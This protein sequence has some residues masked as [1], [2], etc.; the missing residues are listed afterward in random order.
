MTRDTS[1]YAFDYLSAQLRMQTGRNFAKIARKT[2]AGPQNI[3]HFMTHSPWSAQAVID[4]VQQEI[5]KTPALLQGSVLIL[6]ESA[7]EKTSELSV[8]AARQY[9]GRQGKVDMSQMGVFLGYA[10]LEVNLWSWVDAE[11]YLPKHWFFPDKQALSEK[12]GVPKERVFATKW[13]LGLSMILRAHATGLPFEMVACDAHYGQC[14]QFRRALSEAGILYF[15][16]VPATEAVYL[17]C[18]TFA[19]PEWSGKGRVP[20]IARV[21]DQTPA[22]SVKEVALLADT[23]WQ[24]LRVR[25]T[26]RGFLEEPFAFRQVFTLRDGYPVQEWLVM[27]NESEHK[28]SYAFSSAA[29]DTPVERLAQS[30]CVRYFVERCNQDAKSELGYDEFQGQ[31]WRCWEHHVGLTMLSCWFVA[32]TKL[33][34]SMVYPRDPLLAWEWE[35]DVLPALSTSNV[36][37]LLRATMPLPQLS[38]EEAGHLVVTHLVNRT[39]SRKSRLKHRKGASPPT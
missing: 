24:S 5:A 18:P 20:E 13:Q 33:D 2:Q 7:E 21:L 16:D 1:D 19:I 29:P 23:L 36:R 6:D 38:E 9:N 15:A 34:W 17:S 8:G 11:L 4:Q 32:Q 3:Q 10:N 22:L 28:I 27:R 30:K 12:L 14:S 26:E 31:Q 37:E 39:L 35:V 25:A